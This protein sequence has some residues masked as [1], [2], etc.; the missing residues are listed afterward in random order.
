MARSDNWRINK[1][2]L[3]AV[4]GAQILRALQKVA[5]A[6]GLERGW[7]IKFLTNQEMAGI[8]FEKEEIL[9]GAGDS[10]DS[11]PM[12][13]ERFDVLVGK[14]VH[15]VEHWMVESNKIA[16]GEFLTERENQL[17]HSFCNIGEDVVIE[18]C[19]AGSCIAEYQKALLDHYLPKMRK[20][21]SNRLLEV[22]IEYALAHK[23]DVVTRLP[24]ELVEAGME[25]VKLTTELRKEP[26]TY[27]R[28]FL[29]VQTWT[30]IKRV[31][32]DPPKVEPQEQTQMEQEKQGEM[33]SGAES[34][35]D[36]K[37]NGENGEDGI[38]PKEGEAETEMAPN[39][40]LGG[41]EE[42]ENPY[43]MEPVKEERMDKE[44]EQEIDNALEKEIEDITGKVKKMYPNSPDSGAFILREREKTTPLLEPNRELA[45]RLGAIKTI[46]SRLQNRDLHGEKYGK[47]DKRHLHR[48]GTD[49]RVFVQRFKLPNGFPKTKILLDLSGS[50]RTKET[51]E[52]LEASGALKMVVEA[53]VWCYYRE[54]EIRLVRLDEGKM[55]H[56]YES[57]GDTPSGN[58]LLGLS[59]GMAKGELIL[60]LTDGEYNIGIELLEADA[61]VR[62]NGVDIVHILWKDRGDRFVGTNFRVINGIGEFPEAL[63]QIL[64]EQARLGGLK[65]R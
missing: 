35:A 57:R 25:L 43:E 27:S 56:I 22:W 7:K 31:V 24:D 58:A 38:E 6:M 8:D 15:E 12:S 52:V 48:A 14:M 65:G 18:T 49:Q 13:G 23:A 9:I 37:E 50:M 64:M 36:E 61:M 51:H 30:K 34:K 53:E 39:V 29:Y 2:A 26:P 33:G 62:K 20:A 10:F 3:M 44:L 11:A 46:R 55:V 28:N 42:L 17:Y 19:L 21:Q 40:S 47:I 45:K 5:G 1:S 63:A 32:M 4:E 54:S 60:H 41:D 59:V 16:G